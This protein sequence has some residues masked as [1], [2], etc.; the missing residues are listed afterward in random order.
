[1]LISQLENGSSAAS[2]AAA[3]RHYAVAE[4]TELVSAADEVEEAGG[5][6]PTRWRRGACSAWI[7]FCQRAL[8]SG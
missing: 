2:A 1:M 4:N 7:L 6:V 8:R 5:G 3:S